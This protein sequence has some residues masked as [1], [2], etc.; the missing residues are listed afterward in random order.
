[1]IHPEIVVL[2]GGLSFLGEPL[3]AGVAA[4]LERFTMQAFRPGPDV[5]IAALM[6]DVVPI[7]CLLAAKQLLSP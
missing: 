7:G 6:E 5:Q 4:A 3:R 2:G 1:L